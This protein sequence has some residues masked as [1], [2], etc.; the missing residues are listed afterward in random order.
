MINQIDTKTL[1]LQFP[2]LVSAINKLL[3]KQ[4]KNWGY[5]QVQKE[6][7]F[8]SLSIPAIA[9]LKLYQNP[10]SHIYKGYW[11]ELYGFE[12]P[13]LKAKNDRPD[14]YIKKKQK[15]VRGKR[16]TDPIKKQR[17]L[18]VTY[19]YNNCPEIQQLDRI[20]VEFI[21]DRIQETISFSPAE[22]IMPL[23]LTVAET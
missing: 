11:R 22:E 14:I 6:G 19:R 20:I 18:E 7:D 8:Y 17:T 2:S 10:K 15:Q 3:N 4:E 9:S 23:I 5:F 21:R 16:L 12:L 1:A 13:D